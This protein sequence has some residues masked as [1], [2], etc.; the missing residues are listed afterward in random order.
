MRAEGA[1]FVPAVLGIGLL[2]SLGALMRDAVHRIRGR[3]WL[4]RRSS[5]E[6]HRSAMLALG[7]EAAA[8]DDITG[9]RPRAVYA[10][11]GA[12]SLALAGYLLVGSYGN[13]IGWTGWV[14]TIGW[15]WYGYL[16]AVAAFGAS[17]WCLLAIAI[18][19]DR[20]PPWAHPILA[21]T[22][23]GRL[24]VDRPEPAPIEL[25][26]RPPSEGLGARERAWRMVHVDEHAAE[27]ARLVA[28]IWSAAAVVTLSILAL[29]GYLPASDEPATIEIAVSG[30][31]QMGLLVLFGA[32]SLLT[33]RH[34]ATGA[35]VMAAATAGLGIISAIQY[36]PWTAVGITLLLGFPAFLHWL[37]WQ[38]D[39]HLH[40][41][42]FLA[43]VSAI[44]VLGVWAAADALADRTLGPA[45]PESAIAALPPSP[46]EWIWA[47]AT[48]GSS[49]TVVARMT[50][51]HDAVRLAIDVDPGFVHP[52]WTSA[53]AATADAQQI[54]RFEVDGLTADTEY[55]YA[56]EADGELDRVRSGSL[57][58]FPTGAASFRFAFASCARSGSNGAVFDAIRESDPLLYAN[59]GDLH[60]ANLEDDDIEPF[61]DAY[62]SALDAPSQSALYR[63]TSIAYVWDDHDFGG[64]DANRT[65]PSRDAA[66]AAYRLAVPHYP[67]VVGDRVIAQTFTAGR[68]RFLVTD[69]RTERQPP[70]ESSDPTML[71][72]EQLDW[73]ERELRAA[74]TT[75]EVVVWVN[76]SPWIEAPESGGDSWGAYATER[77]RI[78]AMIEDAG[79]T[80]RLVMLSGD[81]HMV[82][83][84]DG[85]NSGYGPTGAGFPVFHAAALDRPGG[86]KGGPYSDGTHP[87]AGQFGTVDVVDDGGP[88]V[89]L[90][91]T[92]RTWDGR[93]LAQRAVELAIGPAGP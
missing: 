14:H 66:G 80:D 59:L 23:F 86:V 79:L 72:A 3:R 41:L 42:L 4:D 51:P 53:Q 40:R 73:L 63:S 39:R 44:A 22:P 81:A 48:T 87:G 60:Y 2:V 46:V 68:V 35:A 57:R 89:T 84:D 70:L 76:G 32:G 31:V 27:V 56:V 65:S 50:D 43:A 71:G 24:T 62:A 9:R 67:L 28:G 85:T 8:R 91:L 74:A 52:T 21:R 64:N 18:R 17:G 55:H 1:M 25:S 26:L 92:G 61:L 29:Q 88:V 34:E 69:A 36:P 16:I 10:V 47:G 77:S 12:V 49:T 58:T 82:A 7:G 11:A 83:I 38:R 30:P 78:A 54:V 90:V 20:P 15:I 33:V 5:V 13:Y 19:W 37:A 93:I 6:G 45:H 75:D